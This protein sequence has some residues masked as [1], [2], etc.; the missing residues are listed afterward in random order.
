MP[1]SLLRRIGRIKGHGRLRLIAEIV[2]AVL[3]LSTGAALGS[4]TASSPTSTTIHGCV[5][6]KTGALSVELRAGA[7]C[8]RGT[9]SLTWTGGKSAFGTGTNAATIGTSAGAE[10]TLGEVQLVAGTTFADN[11]IPADGQLLPISGLNT[12]LFALYRTKYGGNGKTT[13][14]VPNLK[15]A[16]PNG[17]TYVVCASNAVYP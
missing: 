3:L 12:T 15:D 7:R 10:C 16:A 14:G 6:A 17:L 1:G 11:L 8:P 13:F 9:K 2:G 4:V 5:A